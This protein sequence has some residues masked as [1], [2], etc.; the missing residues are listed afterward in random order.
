MVDIIALILRIKGTSR[1]H[2]VALGWHNLSVED[3]CIQIPMSL[4]SLK[5]NTHLNKKQHV[6][7]VSRLTASLTRLRSL[8]I[9]KHSKLRTVSDRALT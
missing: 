5:K 8:N 6:L 7:T 4:T 3:L 9:S 1:S 2:G